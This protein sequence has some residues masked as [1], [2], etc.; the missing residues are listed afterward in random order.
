MILKLKLFLLS[1]FTSLV[2]MSY[3]QIGNTLFL[4]QRN[5]TL[6]DQLYRDRCVGY[7]DFKIKLMIST[8]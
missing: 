4:I 1:V 6:I 5:N 2:T 8:I 7:V 3:L